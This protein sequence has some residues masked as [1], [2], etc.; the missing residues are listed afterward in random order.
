MIKKFLFVLL[1]FTST[2]SIAQR[3]NSSPY[4]VFGIGD[5]FNPLTVEQASMGGIGV[6]FKTNKYLN[7]INPA[8]NANL[9][10]ATYGLAGSVTFLNLKES[11]ASQSG[12]STSL[13]Y[14]ALGFP[15]GKKAGFSAGLQPQ[16][17]VGYSLQ[18]QVPLNSDSPT[19]VTRY[20]GSGGTNR[21][22]GGFGIEVLDGL[23]LGV[24]A[25]FIFG[26]VDNT[27][28]NSRANVALGTKNEEFSTV[29]GGQYKLGIQYQKEL[30]SK[31]QVNAGAALQLENDLTIR[32]R[33]YLYSVSFGSGGAQSPRDT[34]VSTSFKGSYTMPLK[35]TLGVG[36]GKSNKWYA[37]VN[38]EIQ[39]AVKDNSLN[40]GDA[41]KYEN[42]SRL[43]IGGFYLPKI[44]SISSYWNRVTYRAGVRFENTGLLVKGDPT[45]PNNF[46]AID[47]FGIN[48]GLGLPLGK[49][50]A[51]NIGLSTINVGLEYGQRGTTNNFL[52]KEDYFKF[53][54]SLSL[55]D[56]WFRK[57]KIN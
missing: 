32:S 55:N 38:Y 7:F 9:R 19:E 43:S 26:D 33:R 51:G 3:N 52:I 1:I 30:P 57:R 23:S 54:L 48:V 17:S 2:I 16:S 8:A 49:R 31:L 44:N 45:S 47:D 34:I 35:T 12:S 40:V 29:R 22:F 14:I 10:F 50:T 56:L 20:T 5:E 46:T 39:D 11:N 28:L 4:S 37:G 27:I 24:E 13:Q 53:R 25:A 15:I 36:V 42:S 6:A 18:N 21:L 41:Y